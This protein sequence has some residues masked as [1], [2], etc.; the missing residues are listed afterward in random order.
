MRNNKAL[1]NNFKTKSHEKTIRIKTFLLYGMSVLLLLIL[2]SGYILWN[3]L[4]KID[5]RV[6]KYNA[7]V[8][9]QSAMVQVRVKAIYY[10]G[11]KDPINQL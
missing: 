2:L 11:N 4:Q 1:S 3:G 6:E 8:K 9:M 10:I 5:S 7:I